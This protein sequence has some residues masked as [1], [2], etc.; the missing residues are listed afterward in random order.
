MMPRTVRG[1][2]LS[3][4]E[5]EIMEVLFE[6]GEASATQVHERLP[7]QPTY[8]TVRALLVKLEGKGHISH[9][10]EGRKYIYKP[11]VAESKARNQ[12]LKKLVKVF[13]SGSNVEAATAL[14]GNTKNLRQDELDQ[15]QALLDKHKK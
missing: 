13:F 9:F 4:R 5:R 11:V 10:E 2:P 15:L 3:R 6:L 12:A 8:S 1:A 14:L 7:D